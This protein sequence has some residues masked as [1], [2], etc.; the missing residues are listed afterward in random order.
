MS[1]ITQ[2]GRRSVPSFERLKASLMAAA[3]PLPSKE[4]QDE[5]NVTTP[6]VGRGNGDGMT[7]TLDGGS[8]VVGRAS[9]LPACE[10]RT[11]MFT[12]TGHPAS[13]AFLEAAFKHGAGYIVRYYIARALECAI[14]KVLGITSARFTVTGGTVRHE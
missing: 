10:T 5:L 11:L 1:T 14:E 6:V 2:K 12:I 8:P 4:R 7:T 13:F 3:T 9:K